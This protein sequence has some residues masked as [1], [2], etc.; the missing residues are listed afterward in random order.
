MAEV[1]LWGIP[2]TGKIPD[3]EKELK[4][5][6][7]K[8]L[9]QAKREVQELEHDVEAGLKKAGRN[10]E[11]SLD[12]AGDELKEEFEHLGEEI[13]DGIEDAFVALLNAGNIPCHQ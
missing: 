5:V 9:K 6:I 7:D 1:K 10:I 13:K 12:K 4:K 8:G 11:H 3:P 2:G